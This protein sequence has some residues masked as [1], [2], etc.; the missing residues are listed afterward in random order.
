MKW[1]EEEMK[2]KMNLIHNM[3]CLSFMKQVPDNY[4]DLVLTDIPYEECAVENSGLFTKAWDTMDKADRKTFELN[5]FL[6]ESDRIG[7]GSLYIF[8]GIGQISTIRNYLNKSHTTRLVIW[9]KPNPAPFNAQHVFLSGIE[10][11]V[12]GKKPSATFNEF[13]KNTVFRYPK[14]ID[15]SY[16]P[17]TKPLKLFEEFI[18]ISPNAGDKVFDACMGSGTTAIASKALDRDWCGCELESDYVA[19]ANKRLKQVQGSLF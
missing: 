4:F 14:G 9:E 19:I 7:S 10:T 1:T 15:K 6:V 12:W 5:E 17:T 3:D 8:C 16:H 2:E 18:K 13:F 11:C